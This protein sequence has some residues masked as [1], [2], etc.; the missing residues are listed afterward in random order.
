MLWFG[1]ERDLSEHNMYG[2]VSFTMDMCRLLSRF[3]SSFYYLDSLEYKTHIATR[4]L[5]SDQDYDCFDYVDFRKHGSPLKRK[6]WR[7]VVSCYSEK[8]GY[9]HPHEVEI[10]IEVD[11]DDCKWLF[12]NCSVESNDHS[13]ANTKSTGRRYVPHV[14]HRYNLFG[15]K[16]PY[17][18]TEYDAQRKIEEYFPDLLDDDE[19]EDHDI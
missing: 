6:K 13:E 9:N 17:A 19:E 7:S 15:K 18:L 10:G 14:C 5:L 8:Y 11:K 1:P 4:V 12:N 2:N 3:G 16:C